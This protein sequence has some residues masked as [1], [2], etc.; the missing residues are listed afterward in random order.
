[1]Q[2][3]MKCSNTPNGPQIQNTH[4]GRMYHLFSLKMNLFIGIY[5]EPFHYILSLFS[6]LI[7]LVNIS[8]LAQGEFCFESCFL[9]CWHVFNS[10]TICNLRLSSWRLRK[11]DGRYHHHSHFTELYHDDDDDDDD[12]DDDDDQLTMVMTIIYSICT[13]Y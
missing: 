12:Y 2:K 5:W 4:Y 9:Y 1:M 8:T 10:T 7:F 11:L 3:D 13:C 6:A